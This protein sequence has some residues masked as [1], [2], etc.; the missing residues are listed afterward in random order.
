MP[1]LTLHPK[2]ASAGLAASLS[3][4]ILWAVGHWVVVPPEVAAAF[5]AVLGFVGGWL[6]PWLPTPAPKTAP[7]A[8]ASPRVSRRRKHRTPTTVIG[9]TP[10]A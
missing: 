7:V 4:I 8:V 1:A 9:G 6:A 5:T 3:L 2:V 10:T